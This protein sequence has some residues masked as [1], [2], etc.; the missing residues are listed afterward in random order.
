MLQ[1]KQRRQYSSVCRSKGKNVKVYGKK[2]QLAAA[3]YQDCNPEEYT[4]EYFN[5][6]VHT[7]K[8]A[9]VKTLNYPRPKPQIRP[10]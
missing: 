1:I 2:S 3:Q 7:L 4:S 6:D 10:L 9:N 8:T 5:A